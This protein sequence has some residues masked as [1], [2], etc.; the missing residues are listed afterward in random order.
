[1]I[2]TGKHELVLPL[3]SAHATNTEATIV[4][5]LGETTLDP[6]KG[7]VG[8]AVFQEAGEDTFDQTLSGAT[9]TM[10]S[11][12]TSVPLYL[13]D[14][15]FPDKERTESSKNSRAFFFNIEVGPGVVS[16]SH[17]DYN[18]CIP[19][20]FGWPGPQASTMEVLVEPGT[21]TVGAF[22]CQNVPDGV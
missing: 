9:F 19:V 14:D 15:G 5:Q 10:V 22:V 1:M 16:V 21:V 6:S 8:I 2:T 17:P 20:G 3:T 11:S 13:A 4:A 7:H 18:F 12:A